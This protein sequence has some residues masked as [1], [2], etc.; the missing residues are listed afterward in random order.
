MDPYMKSMV[1]CQTVR[2]SPCSPSAGNQ[3]TLRSQ[4]R[5]SSSDL[6]RNLSRRF[7]RFQQ[8]TPQIPSRVSPQPPHPLWSKAMPPS[9]LNLMTAHLVKWRSKTMWLSLPFASSTSSP[10]QRFPIRLQRWC[11]QKVKLLIGWSKATLV[12]WGGGLREKTWIAPTV[13]HHFWILRKVSPFIQYLLIFAS[14]NF[15]LN[16]LIV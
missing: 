11:L 2:Q 10:Q 15:C 3:A 1:L 4:Q 6:W 8:R 16:K 5:T 12:W 7:M 14:A 9:L 13:T